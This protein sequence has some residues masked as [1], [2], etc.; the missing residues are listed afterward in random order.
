MKFTATPPANK[1]SW[2]VTLPPSVWQDRWDKRP[3]SEALVGLRRLRDIDSATAKSTAAAEAWALHPQDQDIELRVDAYNDSLMTWVVAKVLCD[4][5]A[6]DKSLHFMDR[7]E[8]MVR[9]RMTSDGIRRV[10]DE[11]ERRCIET[12]PLHPQ[13][14]DDDLVELS[15][16]IVSGDLGNLDATTANR[17]RKLLHHVLAELRATDEAEADTGT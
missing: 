15:A 8:S 12:S 17:V 2:T 4:P 3:K 9:D 11:Y 16:R 1:P 14:D 10:F 13:V 5:N 6:A 7:A